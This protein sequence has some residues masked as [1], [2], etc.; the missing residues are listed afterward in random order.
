M[1]GRKNEERER[2]RGERQTQ[3]LEMQYKI[4]HSPR[5]DCVFPRGSW[6]SAIA[7]IHFISIF[8]HIKFSVTCFFFSFKFLQGYHNMLC[9]LKFQFLYILQMCGYCT[10][11]TKASL[12][13]LRDISYTHKNTHFLKCKNLLIM[14]GIV[15]RE[16][17]L[18]MQI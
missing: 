8:Y 9:T 18:K 12:L 1:G 13:F 16:I 2:E 5:M 4:S 17:Y 7:F 6:N 15:K 14:K 10:I 11:L 3:I